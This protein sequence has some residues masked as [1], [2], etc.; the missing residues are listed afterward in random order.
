MPQIVKKTV[1]AASLAAIALGGAASTPAMARGS[2]GGGGH[3]GGYG[4]GGHAGGYGGYRG[5]GY[6][7][8]HGGGYGGWG[9]GLAGV[10]LGAAIAEDDPYYY[11]PY[12]AA[13]Y[14]A[15]YYPAYYHWHRVWAPGY[16][17]TWRR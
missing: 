17:W 12:Y 9:A 7:G 4:G 16:G 14:P 13:P 1:L 15:P 10:A 6:G 5:G 2:W 3:A 8:Y 11:P